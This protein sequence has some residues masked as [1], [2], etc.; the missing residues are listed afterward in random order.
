MASRVDGLIVVEDADIG[1][2]NF[3]GAPDRFNKEGGKRSFCLFLETDYAKRLEELGWNIR[4]LPG[5]DEDEPD[6][7]YLQVAV[8]FRYPPR[9]V[10]IAN[11]QKTVLNEMTVGLLDQVRLAHVD[12]TVRPY[13]WEARGNTGVKAYLKTLYAVAEED[14]FEAKYADYPYAEDEGVSF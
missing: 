5:R 14:E 1:F 8:A 9:I 13:N 3:R 7:A 10:L 11:G 12:V 4:W 2:L 6:K